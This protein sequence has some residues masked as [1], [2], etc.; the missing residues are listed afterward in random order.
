MASSF[1]SQFL[2]WPPLVIFNMTPRMIAIKTYYL[3]LYFFKLDSDYSMP[4][5]S[6][7]QRLPIPLRIQVQTP[8]YG[9]Q[10]QHNLI[11]APWA[12]LPPLSPLL[13]PLQPHW[14]PSWSVN[15]IALLL[16]RPLTLALPSLWNVLLSD[17]WMVYSSPLSSFYQ[18]AIFLVVLSLDHLI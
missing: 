12:R 17:I 1:V 2:P 16:L 11:I 18:K 14:P 3:K 5:L 15:R 13:A 7:L 8:S 4:L 10:G 6:I 9:L